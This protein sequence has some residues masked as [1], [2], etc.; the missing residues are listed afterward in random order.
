MTSIG[1][2]GMMAAGLTA[3][4]RLGGPPE[5]GISFHCP[6]NHNGKLPSLTVKG[7]RGA[8]PPTMESSLVNTQIAGRPRRDSNSRTWFRKPMLYPLSYEGFG[9]T[10]R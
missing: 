3:S 8:R 10:A 5:S 2:L 7:G 6:P 1:R 9:R 4:F